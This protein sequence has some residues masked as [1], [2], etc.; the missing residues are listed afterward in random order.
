VKKQLGLSRPAMVA[1][2]L[3]T[4]ALAFMAGCAGPQSP[5]FSPMPPPGHSGKPDYSTILGPTSGRGSRTLTI[6][7]PP[8]I[9]VWL[10]CIGKGT[11][12]VTR[13][14]AVGVICGSGNY[15]GG[16]LTQPTHYRRGQKLVVRIVGPATV[17][18]EVRIDGAPW[19]G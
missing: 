2:A 9:A 13:P 3:A 5:Q 6:S 8:G 19:T 11:V 15:F 12:W 7:A 10:G 17:R 16:G 14:V 1:A 18:W 4:F